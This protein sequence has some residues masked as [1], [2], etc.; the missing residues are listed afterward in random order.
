M[1]NDLHNWRKRRQ[2]T[3]TE[4]KEPSDE[5][6][7]TEAEAKR[8]EPSGESKARE[9]RS[10]ARQIIGLVSGNEKKKERIMEA[11]QRHFTLFPSNSSSPSAVCSY[12]PG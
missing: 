9:K 12:L 5:K 1:E 4:R 11:F 10:L 8:G 7:E 3:K 2:E 6:R